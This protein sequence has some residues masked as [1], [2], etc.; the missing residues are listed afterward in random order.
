MET[1]VASTYAKLVLG[2]LE[3]YCRFQTFIQQSR[4]RFLPSSPSL[5]KILTRAKFEKIEETPD[6]KMCN[7]SLPTRRQTLQSLKTVEI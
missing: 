7:L 6:A 3:I 4:K 5:R 2:I 1:I